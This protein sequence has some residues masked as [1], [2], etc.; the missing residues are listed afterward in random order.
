MEASDDFMLIIGLYILLQ[1]SF[2][3]QHH[4][5]GLDDSVWTCSRSPPLPSYLLF[6][7]VFNTGVCGF[8]EFVCTDAVVCVT[9]SSPLY[10]LDCEMVRYSQ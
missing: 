7:F 5:S 2:Q 10:G 6:V 3:T 4:F 8:E 1:T 9:D